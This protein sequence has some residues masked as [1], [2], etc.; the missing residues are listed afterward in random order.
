M[1]DWPPPDLV[2]AAQ[3]V[4]GTLDAAGIPACLIGGMVVPRWG[5]PRA[6]TDADFSVLAPYGHE[7]HV[8]DVL[9][10]QFQPRRPD[11]RALPSI[12]ASS[13]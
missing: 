11:A 8:L 5:Q 4:L 10:A 12:I 6:T 1:T 3:M 9:L 7:A 13:C 2:S